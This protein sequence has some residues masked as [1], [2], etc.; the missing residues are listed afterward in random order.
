MTREE[1]IKLVKRIKGAIVYTEEE[2][3]ALE[4]LIP[5][6]SD[7]E[8]ERIR[9][10]ICSIIDNLEPK[11]FVGVKKMNVIA[12]LEKQKA[13]ER[14]DR[15]A[16][17][18]NDK[19]SFE[20]ALEKAWKYYNES[21]SRKV[22]SFEDDYIECVFSKGFRE[23]FLYKE[24]QKEQKSVEINEEDERIIEWCISHFKECFRASKDNLEFRQYLNDKIIPWLEKQKELPTNEEMLRT[25]RVEYEKGVA[26]TIAKHEQKEQKSNIE[27]LREISTPADED[28]FEIEKKWEAE[29]NEDLRSFI[30]VKFASNAKVID[31][32]RF[33]VLTWERF[34]D[35]ALE[36]IN[37]GKEK[38]K[39]QKPVEWSEEDKRIL[40][41][42]INMIEA[43]GCWVR[44]EDAVE[45]VSDFLKSLPERFNLQPKQE[46][47]DGD[48][49][50]LSAVI[51]LM[52]SSRAV[53]PFY[54]KM[55]LEGWLKS[56]KN[57]GN[58]Q[59][60]NTN[61][62]SWSEEDERMRNQLIYDVEYHKKEA[63]VSAKKYKVTEAL[64]NGIEKCYDEKIAWLK[65]LRPQPK[66]D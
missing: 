63:L 20:S 34:K 19:E 3:E 32:K 56:L 52:K 44:S 18:Y 65:S 11:D 27:K 66:Q 60:S 53:D 30:S 24:K 17:I 22:D 57:R 64:Y 51:S 8:D 25:L 23:G 10:F 40:N 55:F 42:A 36:L 62:L 50:K 2:K 58:S 61:S 59:K 13:K 21:A 5:E 1:A 16:P 31:G 9:K 54:D 6:L 39:E 26:D 47:S 12:W 29:D 45:Q 7:S 28:W 35:I 4:T 41:E 37:R 38:Q 43:R 46:W 33:A 48:E 15:M 49:K 14:L